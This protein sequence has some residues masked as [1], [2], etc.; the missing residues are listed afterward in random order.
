MSL[1]PMAVTV[2]LLHPTSCASEAH[3]VSKVP[4]ASLSAPTLS[5]RLVKMEG[6]SLLIALS[7]ELKATL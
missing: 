1:E 7:K 3:N 6:C 2:R 5:A 4:C